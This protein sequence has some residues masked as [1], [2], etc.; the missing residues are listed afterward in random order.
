[1]D[2]QTIIEKAKA[3][4]TKSDLLNLLNEVKA[5]L[6]GSTAYPFTI[7]YLLVELD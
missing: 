2:K 4:E 5:D 6:L 7:Y 1:M 3:L